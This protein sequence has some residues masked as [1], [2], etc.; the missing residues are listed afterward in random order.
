[1]LA[2]AGL[3]RT[4]AIL[5]AALWVGVAASGG[6]P[7][8]WL[9]ILLP[10]APLLMTLVTARLAAGTGYRLRV[11]PFAA[12]A[13]AGAVA[14]TAV[15]ELLGD[16]G[17]PALALVAVLVATAA[18]AT[19]AGPVGRPTAERVTSPPVGAPSTR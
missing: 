2:L 8:A 13:V 11:V 12:C 16:A 14:L 7:R 19:L 15:A 10:Q 6:H 18:V 3:L 9:A 5:Y 1:M 4:A 17:L